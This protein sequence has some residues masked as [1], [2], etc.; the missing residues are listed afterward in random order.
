MDK[1]QEKFTGEMQEEERLDQILR[2][3]NL[4][5]ESDFSIDNNQENNRTV[6]DNG[7]ISDS[8]EEQNLNLLLEWILK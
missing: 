4:R 7:N 8:D 6:N 3:E 2:E 5:T 1:V